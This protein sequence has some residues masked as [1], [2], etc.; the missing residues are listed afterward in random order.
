M[1]VCV[2]FLC[3]F[4]CVLRGER[5]RGRE[6]GG[7]AGFKD[8]ERGWGRKRNLTDK[9]TVDKITRDP[10]KGGIKWCKIMGLLII[11]IY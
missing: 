4:L 3:V 10:E 11:R 7:E 2:V 1:R 9:P 8:T 5:E 6:R